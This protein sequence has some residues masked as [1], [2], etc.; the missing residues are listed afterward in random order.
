[1]NDSRE[2]PPQSMLWGDDIC[3]FQARRMSLDCLQEV[4]VFSL[5]K[6]YVGEQKRVTILSLT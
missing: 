4:A 1:M 5:M 6:H 2:S 3:Y